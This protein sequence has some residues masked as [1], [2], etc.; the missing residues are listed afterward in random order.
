MSQPLL[1]RTVIEAGSLNFDL[2]GAG[3]Q[4]AILAGYAAFLNSLGYPVQLLTRVMP[5]DVTPYVTP[6]L[7]RAGAA[8]AAAYQALIKDH[9]WYVRELAASRALLERRFYLVIPAESASV[10]MTGDSHHD[11]SSNLALSEPSASGMS[12][13]PAGLRRLMPGARRAH[14]RQRDA[15]AIAQRLALRADDVVRQLTRFGVAGRRLQ[16]TELIALYTDCLTPGAP[17]S[18]TPAGRVEAPRDVAAFAP[19]AIHGLAG[20]TLTPPADDMAQTRQH[21]A[22]EGDV[23][24]DAD[25]GLH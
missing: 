1:Y 13:M 25:H 8:E 3:E 20:H 12:A 9:L 15:A 11:A 24:A 23:C 7:A 22:S 2:K 17:S 10:G 18:I 16:T 4:E 6:Y 14:E 21:G 5:F 19:L